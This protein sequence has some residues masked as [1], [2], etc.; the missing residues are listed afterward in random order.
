MVRP[1]HFPGVRLD[2]SCKLSS[3]QLQAALLLPLGRT[4]AAFLADPNSE[5]YLAWN[6]SL[7]YASTAAYFAAR[8]ADV[9]V[10]HRGDPE[11]WLSAEQLRQLPQFLRARGEDV[12]EFDGISGKK[13]RAAVRREQQR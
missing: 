4:G 6:R 11:S 8:L 1:R 2:D 12:G 5:V 13:T 3:A 9:L 7:L 10:I